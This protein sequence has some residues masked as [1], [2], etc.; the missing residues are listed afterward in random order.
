MKSFKKTSLVLLIALMMGSAAFTAYADDENINDN[1]N[2]E[3]AIAQEAAAESVSADVAGSDTADEEIPAESNAV[4]TAVDAAQAADSTVQAEDGAAGDEEI[5]ADDSRSDAGNS[6]EEIISDEIISGDGTDAEVS[7]EDANGT[8]GSLRCRII[9]LACSFVGGKYRWG[10]TDPHN[11]V[12]CS[13]FTRYIMNHILGVSLSHSS[14]AQAGEGREISREELQPGD[15]VFYTSGRRIDH[16]AIYMGNDQ[17]VHASSRKT[18]IKVSDMGH[19]KI[20]K[21]VTLF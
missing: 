12:D 3:T 10:G 5:I 9:D 21:Y 15:L 14:A 16:V 18:G 17:V 1:I 2:G 11:G 20:V 7:E 19:R 13:G 6:G 8:E 4:Q